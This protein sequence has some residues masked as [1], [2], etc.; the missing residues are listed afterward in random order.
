MVAGRELR[1]RPRL[2]ARLAA[3]VNTPAVGSAA[4]RQRAV[5]AVARRHL[6]VGT[7]M[8][9]R[10]ARVVATPAVRD[11]AGRWRPRCFSARP[12]FWRPQQPATPRAVSPQF[13]EPLI[14]SSV[15]GPG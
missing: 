15:N 13:W 7:P 2:V 14:V 1:E 12:G 8:I 11:A 5:V 6:D 4:R 9:F 10:E 3:I